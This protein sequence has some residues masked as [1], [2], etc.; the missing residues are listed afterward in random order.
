M[1]HL[2]VI[3]QAC[4]WDILKPVLMSGYDSVVT[5]AKCV[6]VF[7]FLKQLILIRLFHPI[8]LMLTI[9]GT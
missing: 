9:A 8:G 3:E 1:G 4:L 5:L 7:S 6:A 2:H